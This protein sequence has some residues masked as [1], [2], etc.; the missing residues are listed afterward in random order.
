MTAHGM[1]QQAVPSI[2]C[3][4]LGF[5]LGN[6]IASAQDQVIFSSS[7]GACTLTM[8]TTDQGQALR[9]RAFHPA[10]RACHIGRDAMVSILSAGFS[11]IGPPRRS[12]K[13]PSL[14]IGRLI[15]FPWLSQYLAMAASHDRG[16][17]AAR[18]RP[19][20][21]D[22]NRYV[23][24]LLSRKE[25]LAQLEP[26]FRKGGYRIVGVSVEKV[27]VGGLREVPLYHGEIAPGLVPFDAMVWFRLEEE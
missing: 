16:W 15:D 23:A 6:T 12:G 10:G 9:L 3:F 22:I 24:Q 4:V 25:L 17:D 26:A 14:F 1:I 8:E 18:G 21:M 13:Y 5:S 20:A 11:K 27:L 7:V 19:R 2:F